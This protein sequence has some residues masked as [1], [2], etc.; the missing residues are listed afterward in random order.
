VLSGYRWK[1]SLGYY[2]STKDLATHFFFDYLPKG[3]HVL[4]YTLVANLRG[5]FS[6]GISTLQCMYAPEFSAHSK[7]V[8]VKIQ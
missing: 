4:E 5:E 8:R 6:N 3:T 7:G 2:E 1:G